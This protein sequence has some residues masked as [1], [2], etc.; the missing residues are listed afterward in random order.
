MANARPTPDWLAPTTYAHRGL[1]G[2]KA[3]ENSLAAA[4]LAMEA[5]LGIECD[6]Q[7]SGEGTPFVFHDWELDRLTG[8]AGSFADMSD[9]DLMALDL[10]RT[11]QRPVPLDHF[12]AA[13]AG[14]VP[15]L[16][17]LKSLPDYEV[18][19]S[20]ERVCRVLENYKGP[21]A[22]MS[23]DPRVPR[24]FAQHS[25]ETCRGLVGTDSLPNGFEHVWRLP[26][27]LEQS[28]PGFLAVDRRDL[29]RPEAAAWRRTGQPLLSWTIKT[30]AEWNRAQPLADALI[31]E[32]EALA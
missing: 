13:I 31:A 21:H 22:V 11:D 3:P 32:G 24:W 28:N 27:S 4:R 12:L 10:L 23:F 16:I 17:E 25:P 18:E 8:Y 26:E 29:S 9:R 20:S 30:K 15:V 14:R 2:A 6:I 5:G 1:H 19:V 7:L